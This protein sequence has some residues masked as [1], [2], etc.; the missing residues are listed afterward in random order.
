MP[1]AEAAEGEKPDQLATELQRQ[2]QQWPAPVLARRGIAHH[3]AGAIIYLTL[4]A[5]LR[6]RNAQGS[7]GRSQLF[8][9]IKF[10]RVIKIRG[11]PIC[12]SV[13]KLGNVIMAFGRCLRI[14]CMRNE[15]WRGQFNI[16]RRLTG[17][18]DPSF[19]TAISR[20]GVLRIEAVKCSWV[21]AYRITIGVPDLLTH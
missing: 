14:T 4:F 10:H 9:P 18:V 3:R 11:H 7:L 16:S 12:W 6:S 17:N 13:N 21:R 15:I 5:G 2:H 1:D 20:D 19:V 8:C